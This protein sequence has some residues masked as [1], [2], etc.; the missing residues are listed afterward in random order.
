MSAEAR[1]KLSD[2]AKQR[3]EKAEKQSV[4]SMDPDACHGSKSASKGESAPL[5]VNPQ[6]NPQ[7]VMSCTTSAYLGSLRG[8]VS[9]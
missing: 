5:I 9:R 3:G 7:K 8:L 6:S 1:K 4:G 2:L